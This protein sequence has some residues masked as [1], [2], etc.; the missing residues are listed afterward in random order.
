MPYS[1]EEHKHRFAIWA[2]GS[3]ASVNGCFKVW[4]AKK[5]LED[6]RL[7]EVARSIT[8]LPQPGEFDDQHLNWRERI[9]NVARNYMDNDG[10]AFSFTH[11]VAAKLIN[12]YLKPIFICG[13][14]HEDLKV[15]AIHPPI[16]SVLLD[17]LYEQNI[18][19]QKS[20]WQ[21]ARK[22]RWSKLN[23]DQ[24]QN[25]ISAIKEALPDGAGL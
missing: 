15:K 2:A 19:E 7:D 5:I 13:D 3:A 4:Q 6:A 24:Y 17:A 23:S 10:N 1:I 11:G 8:N 16:D 12:I 9:I 25:V 22:I 18:G 21:A 20:E 14:N